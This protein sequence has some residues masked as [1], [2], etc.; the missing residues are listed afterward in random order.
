V[1]NQVVMQPVQLPTLI[2]AP[3]QAAIANRGVAHLS[4]PIDIAGEAAEKVDRRAAIYTGETESTPCPGELDAAAEL[5]GRHEK[6]AILAGIGASG[7]REELMALADTLAAPIVRTLRAMD[8]VPDDNPFSVGGHGNLGGK[9]AAHAMDSCDALLM[10]GTDFPYHDYYPR[11]VPAVQIDVEPTR[12]GRRYPIT[13]GLAGHARPTLA[14]L[15]ERLSRRQNR[16]FLEDCRGRMEDWLAG[17]AKEESAE[18]EPIAPQRLTR[19]VGEAARDDAIFLCDTGTVTAW[20]ARHLH[21]RAEQRFT[22]SSALA[23]MAFALPAALGA[24]LTYP[25][26]QVIALAGDGGF[27]M[28]MSDFAT[29]VKYRL[30]VKVVVFN[31]RKLAL[32]KLE[33][34]A[35]GLPEHQTELED[36]DFAAAAR[37]CGGEGSTVTDPNA[38]D[39]ALR[40]ALESPKPWVVDVHVDPDA[41]IFPPKITADQAF[42]FGVAKVKEWTGG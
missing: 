40:E 12:L 9:P 14:G 18:S 7:A 20:A 19:A 38:L 33:Q 3:C 4:L 34:E 15:N 41:L 39:D 27:S 21:I 28:L 32:I 26:R 31:N 13:L 1:F 22:L 36:I 11:D 35:K 2:L 30:P 25:D 10:V 24:Q 42:G 16:R 8:L 5:L 17:A 37:A 23:S 6:V 29:A